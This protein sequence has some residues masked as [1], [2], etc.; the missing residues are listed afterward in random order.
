MKFKVPKSHTGTPEE[1]KLVSGT[2]VLATADVAVS[3][4]S[5]LPAHP[6]SPGTTSQKSGGEMSP[7]F[8][9]VSTLFGQN[10]K[11]SNFMDV[12]RQV[13]ETTPTNRDGLPK[14]SSDFGGSGAPTSPPEGLVTHDSG[15]GSFSRKGSYNQDG[16]A[17]SQGS[18][19][20][21]WFA[22]K[23]MTSLKKVIS[24]SS[25]KAKPE[26]LITREQV[27]TYHE[28]LQITKV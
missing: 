8:Q 18:T 23:Q 7:Q 25:R 28:L 5:P 13:S 4:E 26:D 24:A 3:R 12:V 2:D 11:K 20:G 15:I 22:V 1:V 16:A 9:S 17:N 27:K 21:R 10:N 6:V 19:R 14:K